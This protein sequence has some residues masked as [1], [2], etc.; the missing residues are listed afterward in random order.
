MSSY[1]NNGETKPQILIFELGGGITSCYL[2][3]VSISMQGVLGRQLLIVL[4]RC[5]GQHVYQER[6]RFVKPGP[7]MLHKAHHQETGQ[8]VSDALHFCR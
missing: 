7:R 1:K 2:L 5:V 6:S 8:A 4:L 3:S